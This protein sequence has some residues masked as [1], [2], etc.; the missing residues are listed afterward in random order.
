MRRQLLLMVHML[1]ALVSACEGING[2]RSVAPQAQKN[3]AE[4][5]RR[6]TWG[7]MM[8]R[9]KNMTIEGLGRIVQ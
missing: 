6:V 1:G 2:S 8:N 5:P 3:R 7:P 4:E 9:K